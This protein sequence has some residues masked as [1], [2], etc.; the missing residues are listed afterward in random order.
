M[1]DFADFWIHAVGEKGLEAKELKASIE[2]VIREVWDIL[3]ARY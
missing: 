3:Q 2:T 1:V